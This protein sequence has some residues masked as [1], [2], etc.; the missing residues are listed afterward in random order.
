MKNQLRIGVLTVVLLGSASCARSS[1][2]DNSGSPNPS[3]PAS[4]SARKA[5]PEYNDESGF[6][7]LRDAKVSPESRT[8]AQSVFR[9]LVPLRHF[10]QKISVGFGFGEYRK[11]EIRSSSLDP[12]MK[13]VLVR[14]IEHCEESQGLLGLLGEDC[15][16][17][18]SIELGSAFLAGDGR[19]LWTAMHVAGSA[20]GFSENIPQADSKYPPQIFVFDDHDNLIVDPFKDP[21]QPRQFPKGSGDGLFRM[22][23]EGTQND[24]VSFT[25]ARAIG[26]PLKIAASAPAPGERISVIGYPACTNCVSAS[27]AASRADFS[28]RSPRPNSDGKTIKVSF[29]EVADNNYF[30]A[31]FD[32]SV[33]ERP[34]ADL[35]KMIS[36]TADVVPGNSGGPAFNA[37]GEVIG[38]LSLGIFKDI[39]GLRRRIAVF[40]VP[41]WSANGQ[42]AA[43]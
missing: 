40:V 33:A 20:F 3:P 37:A 8:N 31:V 17:S 26:Q 2:S 36:T 24:Y 19:T 15:E 41:P 11:Y 32:K 23:Y 6:Y 9:M 22:M 25:L 35:N 5:L 29:G 18:F 34:D 1:S 28:S 10:R 27:Q 7:D 42:G 43:Q 30:R 13:T 38:M 21:M 16:V 4:V 14:Q 39:S 12:I